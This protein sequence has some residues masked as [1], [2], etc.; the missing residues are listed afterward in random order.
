MRDT[1]RDRQLREKEKNKERERHIYEVLKT[2][3]NKENVINLRVR[4]NQKQ[5]E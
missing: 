2:K 1:E 4:Y 3:I 5:S